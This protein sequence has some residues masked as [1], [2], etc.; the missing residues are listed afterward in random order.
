MILREDLDRL[1]KLQEHT[2]LAVLCT[3]FILSLFGVSP[4]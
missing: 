4:Q 2:E 1:Q 3:I